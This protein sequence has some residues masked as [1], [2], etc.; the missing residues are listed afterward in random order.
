[1]TSGGELCFV[2]DG[3][4]LSRWA[5]GERRMGFMIKEADRVGIPV[6]TTSMTLIEAYD[7]KIQKAA[8]QWALS[9]IQV[10]PVTEKIAEEAIALLLNAGLRGHKCAI[11]AALAA[12]ALCLPGRVTIFTSDEDDMGKLCG[13]RVVIEPL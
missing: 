2:L 1:M 12:V 6:I 7:A 9:S 3:E 8:W 11:D 10:V 4:G 13:N 5:R